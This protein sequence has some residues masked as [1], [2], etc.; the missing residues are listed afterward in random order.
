MGLDRTVA[1][2]AEAVAGVP[3]FYTPRAPEPRSA[4]EDR[5]SD[6]RPTARS[7]S[8]RPPRRHRSSP[9]A[10]TCSSTASSP[11]SR[12]SAR[13]S[14]TGTAASSSVPPPATSTRRPPR[15]TGSPSTR[16]TTSSN[17]ANRTPTRSA[18]PASSSSAWSGS[19]PATP[20]PSGASSAGPPD[21]STGRRRLTWLSPASRRRPA[22]PGNRSAGV[23]WASPP[24]TGHSDG[25]AGIGAQEVW[26]LSYRAL[27]T[28]PKYGPN[29]RLGRKV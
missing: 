24:G 4:R 27:A 13:P 12:W 19:L 28:S 23:R 18:C 1:S 11:T 15:R 7:R 9:G 5:R 26:A 3:A 17:R 22:P 25:R 2:A 8:P 20:R 16:W 10:R 21:R 6:T 14:A 29:M